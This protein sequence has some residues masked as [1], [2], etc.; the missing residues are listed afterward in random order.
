MHL[1]QLQLM[2]RPRRPWEA[3]DLGVLLARRHARTLILLW[4][5]LSAPVLGLSALALPSFDY[6]VLVVWWLKPL[7]ERALLYVLSREIF[8]QPVGVRQAIRPFWH[9]ARFQL[10][11]A[12]TWRRLSLTRSFDLPITQLEGLKGQARKHRLHALHFKHGAQ[13]SWLTVLLVHFEGFFMFGLLALVYAF[14]PAS[15]EVDWEASLNEGNAWF[16][17]ASYLAMAVIAPVYV[18]AGFML[19]LNR[20]IELEGWD[21]ELVFRTMAKDA[22][23][24]DSSS[25]RAS[26]SSGLLSVGVLLLAMG[27]G[28][29][30]APVDAETVSDPQLQAALADQADAREV[31]TRILASD[32]FHEKE[33]I[34]LP[35]WLADW[36]VDQKREEPTRAKNLEWIR[37]LAESIEVLLWIGVIGLLIYLVYRYR[38]GLG[39]LL[40]KTRGLKRR[41]SVPVPEVLFGLDVRP[42]TLPTDIV[43]SAHDYWNRGQ[44]REAL[45]LL[46]RGLLAAMVHEVGV[47][48]EL[49]DT[50]LECLER[51]RG[52]ARS[53]TEPIPPEWIEYLARLTTHWRNLAYAHRPLS[54]EHWLML[55]EQWPLPRQSTEEAS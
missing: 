53:V 50:E 13:G 11:P 12:L 15:V 43:G 46:Y 37:H 16:S 21:I 14:L 27:F 20:R 28:L 2:A 39:A 55:C 45:A 40:D 25:Q 23:L 47:P 29:S 5:L 1:E 30:S 31:I 44:T 52:Y 6:A 42:E 36:K 3:V 22:E 54:P 7:F 34:R 49:G 48:F 41:R 9:Y 33:V 10:L 51:T 24:S 35:K 18:A 19:Y 8:A 38:D 17:L 4:L 26:R 32:A